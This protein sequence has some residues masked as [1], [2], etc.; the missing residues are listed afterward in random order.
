[1]LKLTL[2]AAFSTAIKFQPMAW[3]VATTVSPTSQL[4]ECGQNLTVSNV[5][6]YYIW[7]GKVEREEE[8]RV[9]YS[10][11]NRDVLVECAEN[12]HKGPDGYDVPMIIWYGGDVTPSMPHV[13]LEIAGTSDKCDL[14]KLSDQLVS[15]RIVAC[16]Q[17]KG[18]EKAYFKTTAVAEQEVT[19]LVKA[20]GCI[21]LSSSPIGG[22]EPY[23]KWVDDNVLLPLKS[24][25]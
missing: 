10:G 14:G 16:A 8:H 23:L 3:T 21:V 25:L 9:E 18:T 20:N 6:S 22:S 12:A 19:K 17:V 4:P 2:R 7:E 11:D 24:D 15:R 13:Q 5:F 1:M